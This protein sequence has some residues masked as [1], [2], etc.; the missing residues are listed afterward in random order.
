MEN[1]ENTNP[2]ILYAWTAPLRPYKKRGKNILRFFLALA[3]LLSI[4]IFFFGDKILL[5]LVWSAL[6]LF[7]VLTITPPP[8]VEN[9]ISKFGIETA[10]LTLRWELLS[11]FF[12]TKRFGYDVVTLV[13]HAP[14]YLH[15]YM[16]IPNDE[17]KNKVMSLLS[18]HLIYQ[19]KPERYFV[20]TLIDWFS[21]LIP[22]DDEHVTASSFHQKQAQL[23]P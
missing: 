19:E 12:F 16:V 5:L 11:H 6:F 17:V 2:Q 7:Y 15:S 8:D 20:D 13:G 18:E 21:K 1:V 3:F 10:G 4:I 14:Y 9:K 22:D 23:S